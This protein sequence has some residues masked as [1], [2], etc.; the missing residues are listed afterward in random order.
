MP[1]AKKNC[2]LKSV[3]KKASKNLKIVKMM[4]C[5]VLKWPYL[6]V[7]KCFFIFTHTIFE[8]HRW[9]IMGVVYSRKDVEFESANFVKCKATDC[10][11]N[12]SE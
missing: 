4:N 11:Q 6:S 7:L 1:F 9:C 2:L 5:V 12:T 8:Q 3:C 10:H